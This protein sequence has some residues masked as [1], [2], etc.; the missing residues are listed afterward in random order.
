[1]KE[2]PDVNVVRR[3][4]A[5]GTE[6]IYYYHRATDTRLSAD[7]EERRLEVMRL[8][9]EAPPD[10]ALV[11]GSLAW[12]IERY[13]ESEEWTKL[14]ASS[15]ADYG[16]HFSKLEAEFG[17]LPVAAIGR[18]GV[19][20]Y[21]KQLL[22]AGQP[23]NAWHR[24]KKL[25]TLLNFARHELK[26]LR[27][28]PF[29]DVEIPSP[30]RRE[31]VWAPAQVEAFLE[32]ADPLMRRAFLLAAHTAQRP[33]D[34][35][36]MTYD[37]IG[38]TIE[39][40]G[41]RV[42]WVMLRHPALRAEIALRL[43]PKSDLIAP[44]PTGVVWDKNNFARRFRAAREAAGL[45]EGLQFR[46]L[47]R[48]VMVRLAEAGASLAQITAVSGHSIEQTQK[49]LEHYIPRNRLMALAAMDLLVE[50]AGLVR[51]GFILLQGGRGTPE[52]DLQATRTDDETGLQTPLQKPTTPSP[53]ARN[54]G[55]FLGTAGWSDWGGGLTD[56]VW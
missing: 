42:L 6:A 18:E 38:Q 9:G 24:L 28:N 1:V 39:R 37:C 51:R 41:R 47:R 30:P 44:S 5:D 53:H 13:K 22:E 16:W 48:T 4:R 49:I 3:K 40:G 56:E 34:C 43:H 46:D 50:N 45:P 7:P 32:K 17:D 31:A 2:Q 20:L 12:V 36:R 35:W 14:R 54:R 27:E 55:K 23:Y 33:A 25:K 29:K 8:N 26:L 10:P 11:P 15:R 21:R 52:V 19:K